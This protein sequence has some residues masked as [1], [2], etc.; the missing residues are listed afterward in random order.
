MNEIRPARAKDGFD[1]TDL[2]IPLDD[3]GG[4]QLS[5]SRLIRGRALIFWD[6]ERPGEK[7]DAI[8]TDQITPAKDCVSESLDALDA[9]WKAGAFRHLMPDF[10]RRVHAGE[11]FLVAG[12]RFAIGS[13]HE[14]SPAGL[15]AVAEEAGLQ[16]VIICGENMGDIFRRNAF[17][18]GLEVIQSPA[19]VRDAR[20][21]DELSYDR[22]TRALTNETRGKS[23]S[24][25]ELT[26][27][28][29][30]IRRSGGIFTIGRREFPASVSRKPRIE[31]PDEEAARRLTTTEQIVWAHRVDKDAEVKPGATLRVYADLLPALGRHG[32]VLNPHL[33]P[34]HGRQ[35][36]LPAASGH[37]ERPLRL[38]GQRGGRQADLDRA[39]LRACPENGHAVL[40]DPR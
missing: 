26:A 6:P 28:E 31:W 37:R 10:R 11:T 12:N 1:A 13:S 25:I 40:R 9:K 20:D 33:Q 16:M 18:L 17:N 8:D 35:S 15:K 19:A 4:A 5:G 23:Y 38:H 32:S 30:E 22:E 24:P 21:G 27:K 34:N 7:L 3:D 39:R 29:D 14:M 2:T 36:H